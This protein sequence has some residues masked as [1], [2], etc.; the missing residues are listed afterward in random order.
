VRKAAALLLAALPALGQGDPYEAEIEAGRVLFAQQRYGEAAARFARA[1]A[2]R[3]RE[4]RAYAFRAMT[5]LQQADAEKQPERRKDVLREAERAAARLV[6][7]AGVRMTDPLVL[8]L[9]GTAQSIEGG[10]EVPAYENLKRALAAPPEATLPYEEIRL[11]ENIEHAFAK[12]SEIMATRLITIGEFVHADR[13]LE[14]ADRFLPETD[15]QREQFEYQYAVVSEHLGRL[16]RAVEH[17]RKAARLAEGDPEAH[18]MYMATVAMVLL[19]HARV[20]E[21]RAVLAELPADSRHPDV[22]GARCTLLYKEALRRPEGPEMGR[23]LEAY[24]DALRTYP[25][26]EAYLLVRQFADLVLEK[27]GPTEAGRERPLLE[28]AV[29]LAERQTAL[30][31]ECPSL[32]YALFRLHKLLGDAAKEIHYQDLHERRKKEWTGREQYDERGRAR[33]R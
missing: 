22:L 21:G 3:P 18:Q 26:D 29:R 1:E 7:D 9:A 32:Y 31:P 23:A 25:E 10:K 5:L 24:R 14:A 33:C 17:L 20:E 13:I 12:A 16:E 8:F 11:R 27:V 4:W 6:K 30:R 2:I 19:Q 28:E 15:P